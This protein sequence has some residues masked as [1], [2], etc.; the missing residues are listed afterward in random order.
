MVEE[1][2]QKD[3]VEPEWKGTEVEQLLCLEA[4]PHEGEHGS[5]LKTGPVC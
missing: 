3:E 4:D 1:A 5:P 2:F